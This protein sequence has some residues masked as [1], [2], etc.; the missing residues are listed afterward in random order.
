[1]SEDE[2]MRKKKERE[3][4]LIYPGTRPFAAPEIMRAWT[5]SDLGKT[6]SG[7]LEDEEGDWSDEDSEPESIP[8]PE[9]EPETPH[10]AVHGRDRVLG[11]MPIVSFTESNQPPEPSSSASPTRPW[12]RTRAPAY[13]SPTSSSASQPPS[14]ILHRR[15]PLSPKPKRRRPS[16]QSIVNRDK[17]EKMH[18]GDPAPLS[19][20]LGDTYAL[21]VLA[22]CLS[23]D[24]LV[25][26]EPGVQMREEWGAWDEGAGD[27]E[28]V[29][30]GIGRKYMRRVREREKCKAGDAVDIEGL[31][32]RE[33][34]RRK[35]ARMDLDFEGHGD[36]G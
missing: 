11:R 33:R 26:C 13:P 31:L 28:G 24:E 5:L 20:A 10:R 14:P 29:L 3:K 7:A 27:G 4:D 22:L 34:E 32:W 25:D 16:R 15:N 35:G 19:P 23:R 21:G 6:S 1:M 12:T 17:L 18:A 9:P 8:E 2:E 36:I 30:D